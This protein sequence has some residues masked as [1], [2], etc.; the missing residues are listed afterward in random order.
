[1][2]HPTWHTS[3]YS[4]AAHQECVEVRETPQHVDL[5]DAQH[6]HLGQVRVQRQEWVAFL[7]R[8]VPGSCSPERRVPSGQ[9]D[10]GE[11]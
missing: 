7:G 9:W 4:G 11:I 1:M 2:S 5:R 6:R 3:S 8:C 10:R